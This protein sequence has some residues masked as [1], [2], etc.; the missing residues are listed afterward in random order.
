[1][2]PWEILFGTLTDAS[3]RQRF[4][5]LVAQ[6]ACVLC[7]RKGTPSLC[8]AAGGTRYTITLHIEIIFPVEIVDVVGICASC[9][10]WLS[11]D[12]RLLP[13]ESAIL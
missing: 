3:I 6:S 11:V 7:R 10:D 13:D 1:V 9:M 12:W 8:R 5:T 4:Q 2:I